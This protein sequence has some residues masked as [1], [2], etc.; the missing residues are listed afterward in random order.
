MTFWLLAWFQKL[1]VEDVTSNLKQTK[2]TGKNFSVNGDKEWCYIKLFIHR[3]FENTHGVYCP[4][5]KHL[6][7]FSSHDG[8]TYNPV[9][10]KKNEKYPEKVVQQKID[11]SNS[12][13]NHDNNPTSDDNVETQVEPDNATGES[14]R[15][16]S[17]SLRKVIDQSTSADLSYD[18]AENEELIEKY[19]EEYNEATNEDGGIDGMFVDGLETFYTSDHVPRDLMDEF[20]MSEIKENQSNDDETED[21]ESKDVEPEAVAEKG[22][23]IINMVVSSS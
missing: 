14:S 16:K 19:F 15:Y 17:Q 8:K 6:K 1:K 3:H 11:T 20:N 13:G 10:L 23:F 2:F 4:V 22:L 12:P 5:G 7:G 9:F 21:D 18:S